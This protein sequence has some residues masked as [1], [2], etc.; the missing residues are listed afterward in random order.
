MF[1]SLYLIFFLWNPDCILTYLSFHTLS[2]YLKLTPSTKTACKLSGY[3]LLTHS[4]THV[5]VQSL[6]IWSDHKL[7][8]HVAIDFYSF[9]SHGVLKN[10]PTWKSDFSFLFKSLSPAPFSIAD[11]KLSSYLLAKISCSSL[12]LFKYSIL[13]LMILLHFLLQLHIHLLS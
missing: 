12:S 13:L 5:K 10:P 7:V 9:S 8:L 6:N 3:Q 4:A 11:M 1:Y 2:C